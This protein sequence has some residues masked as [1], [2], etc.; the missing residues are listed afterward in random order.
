MLSLI[1]R[2]EDNREGVISKK[3]IPVVSFFKS[4]GQK[5]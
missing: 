1:S 3:Y 4:A 2:G 5:W